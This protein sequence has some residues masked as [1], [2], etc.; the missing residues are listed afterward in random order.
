[1]VLFS[2]IVPINKPTGLNKSILGQDGGRLQECSGQYL[3]GV[4]N[5][6][7]GKLKK[8]AALVLVGVL[9]IAGVLASGGCGKGETGNAGGKDAA[10]SS[11]VPADRILI[12]SANAESIAAELVGEDGGWTG[13]GGCY[14]VKDPQFGQGIF[15]ID[16][17]DGEFYFQKIE[18]E[19]LNSN[20][21]VFR[22]EEVLYEDKKIKLIACSAQGI[23]V[24]ID[25]TD[26]NKKNSQD[27]TL[28][29]LGYGGQEP[30][31]HNITQ[32]LD[33]ASIKQM[34]ADQEGRLFLMS[35]EKVT[36]FSPEGAYVTG[37]ALDKG[38]ERLVLGGDGQMYVVTGGGEEAARQEESAGKE[39]AGQEENVAGQEG[40]GDISV[41]CR[42]DM[43]KKEAVPTAEY[44]NYVICDG[45]EDWL[46]ILADDTGMYGVKS[47]GEEYP[48]IAL[49]AELGVYI[50]GLKDVIPLSEG[51]FLLRPGLMFLILEPADPAVM[52]VKKILTLASVNTD[53]SYT[54]VAAGFN[55]VS[56][57]YAIRILDYTER[58][59]YDTREAI[60]RLNMDIVGG[61]YP[62]MFNFSNLPEKYY[63]DKGLL[64]DLYKYMDSDPGINREDY[65]GL[66][67]LEI[68]GGL[69]FAGNRFYIDT[70]V[71]LYSRF[72]D[73]KGWSLEEYL[74]IQEETG[75]EMMYNVTKESFLRSIALRY[76][77]QNVDWEKGTCSFDSR[78]FIDILKAVGRIR[79]SPQPLNDED[80]PPL[81]VQ[82]QDG[83]RVAVMCFL[84]NIN[85]ISMLEMV[86]GE[87]LS[88]IGRPTPDGEGGTV[89]N[90]D[91]LLGICSKG[92]V[93]GSWEFMKYMLKE[94]IKGDFV[95]VATSREVLDQQLDNAMKAYEN[96]ETEAPFDEE[97]ARII[98]QLIDQGVYY[99]KA[100][101]K[102]VDIVME[103][104]A[105]FLDGKKTAE[106]TAAVI[107]S[108]VSILAAESK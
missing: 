3:E 76:A 49:W 62:D 4:S 34:K 93:E 18:F 85:M 12:D 95:G 44:Q 36:V 31:Q 46:Y 54:R 51:R 99:G 26:Y 77:A 11:A 8:A 86:I 40:T 97:D 55:A 13:E 68:D 82:L 106:E 19:T 79:E 28:V 14:R 58:G 9:V 16:F 63:L 74:D 42:L 108:R 15:N 59:Q 35:E 94:G 80:A 84:G 53:S 100:S 89:L 75:G 61:N 10:V 64:Q 103:E 23:W 73:A 92:N 6:M 30:E 96:G 65:V 5:M 41:L 69:Y 88:F 81:R 7:E 87:E 57:E 71:G 27:F 43:D 52:K 50:E 32:Y 91:N 2:N 107:Q 39:A 101:Q 98:Y 45:T 105:A 102:V 47:S 90:F 72:G 37:I 21:Q 29:L 25:N 22:G 38:A 48:P 70:A 60:D 33:Y 67:K 1:M 56:N 20:M 24:L 83:S 66:D 17:Y 104:A 78:E